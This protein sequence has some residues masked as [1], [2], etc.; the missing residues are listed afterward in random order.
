M[1]KVLSG[2]VI[3]SLLILQGCASA[4]SRLPA[5]PPDATAKAEIPGM[6]GVRY[7]AGVDA[8][9]L[10][11][12]ARESFLREAEYLAQQGHKGPLPPAVFVAI[13]GGGDNGGGRHCA[14][15]RHSA[16]GGRRP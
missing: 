10:I 4:P 13:S 15:R 9:G 6:P 11:R 3:A 2:V 8:P 5:V 12:A 16:R 14:Q 1:K 7:A